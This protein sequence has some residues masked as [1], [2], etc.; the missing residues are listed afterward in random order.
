MNTPLNWKQYLFHTLKGQLLLAGLAV[1][2]LYLITEHSAHVLGLLPFAVL[3]L[4]CP[5]L[6]MSMHGGHGNHTD[7]HAGHSTPQQNDG[8][9]DNPQSHVH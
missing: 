3:L 7:D 8:Q 5:L 4:L 6:M 2:A 9:S 1:V